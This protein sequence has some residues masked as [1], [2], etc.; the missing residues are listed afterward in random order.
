MRNSQVPGGWSN[1][2]CGSPTMSNESWP[3]LVEP[4]LP[5]LNH[6]ER[7]AMGT[8]EIIVCEFHSGVSQTPGLILRAPSGIVMSSMV[9]AR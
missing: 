2:C 9:S 6:R 7:T 4:H 1:I 3:E 5:C 8:G